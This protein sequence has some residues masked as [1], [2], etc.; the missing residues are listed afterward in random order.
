MFAICMLQNMSI[1][2]LRNSIDVPIF[3][4]AFFE[5]LNLL[6]QSSLVQ[7]LVVVSNPFIMFSF[8]EK[9]SHFLTFTYL[10]ETKQKYLLQYLLKN[11]CFSVQMKKK[12]FTVLY[13]LF[14][15]LCLYF[16]FLFKFPWMFIIFFYG[17]LGLC[18]LKIRNCRRMYN[19]VFSKFVNEIF[20]WTWKW[21]KFYKLAILCNPDILK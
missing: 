19:V 7:S 3:G 17:I 11:D 16:I 1:L 4:A 2:N 8:Q 21:K 10:D 15:N 20:K 14:F 5:P 6:H 12:I 18:E 13:V 9:L